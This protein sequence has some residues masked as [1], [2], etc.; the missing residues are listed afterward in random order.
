MGI[1]GDNLH[2]K[3]LKNKLF[4]SAVDWLI[5]HNKVQNQKE[6][7]AVTKIQEPTLS[8]IRN[9]KKIVSD[10]T[11]RKLIESFPGLFNPDYF[12]GQSVWMLMQDLMEEKAK[13]ETPK[14]VSSDIGDV[15]ELYSQRVRLVDDIR[16]SLKE[17]LAEVR[18]LTEDLHT[19]VYDFRDATYRLTQALVKLN[20]NN[21]NTS[22]IGM[23][24]DSGQ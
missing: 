14:N 17:E 18:A 24:A 1:I 3:V 2:P 9:D 22:Q 7:A 16:Q 11:I 4:I 13:T 10:K 12:R 21:N 8:N 5:D 23:A 15:M 6:L 19:A 20:G